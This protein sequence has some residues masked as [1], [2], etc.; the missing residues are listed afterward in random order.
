MNREAVSPLAVQEGCRRWL[1]LWAIVA[2]VNVGIGIVLSFDP[3]RAADFQTVRSWTTRWLFHGD[4]LYIA[5]D[6]GTDY[7]PYAIVALSPISL[8]RGRTG[9]FVWASLNLLLLAAAPILAARAVRPRV[10]AGTVVCLAVVFLAWSGT[11]TLLQFSLLGVVLGL[12]AMTLAERRRDF[13]GVCLGLAMTKPQIGA[14]FL[15]WAILTRRWRVAAICALT[16]LTGT[17]LFC[18]RAGVSPLRVATR[19]MEILTIYYW[20]TGAFAG[21]T[22]VEPLIGA[23]LAPYSTRIVALVTSVALLA[24]VCM[25]G[26]TRGRRPESLYPAPALAAIWSLLTFYHLTYGMVV[27]LPVAAVLLLAEDE[28]TARLRR[29]LFWFMQFALVA[30]LAG[31]S[32]RISGRLPSSEPLF[33]HY[34][35]VVL[36]ILFVG[37]WLVLRKTRL[38][39]RKHPPGV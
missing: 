29:L 18:I 36:L 17:L 25:E 14:P 1:P 7:P 9:V 28:G 20:G 34:Y 8:L 12:A 16:I 6:S 37:V 30:D 27:L 2:V 39:Y 5:A 32:R 15:L 35:R 38:A 10:R 3:D 4:D 24:V 26:W 33:S 19:Y 22:K 11:K 21:V 13:S 31:V 23:W